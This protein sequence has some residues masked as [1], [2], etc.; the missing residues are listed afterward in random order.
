MMH[1]VSKR[2]LAIVAHQRVER[3]LDLDMTGSESPRG[4]WRSSVSGE[5]TAMQMQVMRLGIIKSKFCKLLA[6]SAASQRFWA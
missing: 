6:C 2:A 3:V 1:S 4:G 5:A